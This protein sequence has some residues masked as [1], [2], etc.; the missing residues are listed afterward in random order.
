M[1]NYIEKRN[2]HSVN[3]LVKRLLSAR[4]SVNACPNNILSVHAPVI[5]LPHASRLWFIRLFN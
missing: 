5:S 1:L 3:A 4:A 2:H